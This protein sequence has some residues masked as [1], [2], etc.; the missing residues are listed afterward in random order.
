VTSVSAKDGV[1]VRY[2]DGSEEDNYVPTKLKKMIADGVVE[3]AARE[4]AAREKV[5]REEKAAR[6]KV[7]RQE[8]EAREKVQ[9]EEKEAREEAARVSFF[10]FVNSFKFFSVM[11]FYFW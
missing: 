7:L 10:F 4:Q 3:T 2:A 8:K 6:E 9:R 1:T 5:L 11:N